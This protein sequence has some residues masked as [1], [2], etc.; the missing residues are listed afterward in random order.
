[1]IA[2]LLSDM[3]GEPAALLI[4]L[5]VGHVFGDFLVQ[6]QW[7]ASRKE[8]HWGVLLLHVGLVFVA[9][10]AVLWP[11]LSWRLITGLLGLSVLH[12]VIDAARARACGRWGA[13]LAA[14]FVDQVLHLG[15]GFILW[16]L[17]ISW[18]G[19]V[20]SAWSPT[21]AWLTW[22]ARWS[23]VAAA[24]VFNG[25]GGTRIVRGVLERFPKA[26]PSE[27]DGGE[28]EYEMG[29]TIGSLERYL[30]L[31]LVLFNQWAALGLI[32]AVKAIARFPEFTRQR[33]KD[34]AEYYLIGTLTSVLVA[35]ASGII[36]G[37]TM[38]WV[39]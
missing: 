16:R 33:H 10:A 29:R 15:A 31:T 25:R 5:V 22:Y 37:L 32:M 39:H 38:L 9:H 18:T 27:A 21:V 34:F 30:A 20:A 3:G 2:Q 11:F 12:L 1:M 23:M 35:L 26:V 6:N 8:Q 24:Y 17:V 4:L 36:V 7:I 13:S 19:G 14:F 28:N